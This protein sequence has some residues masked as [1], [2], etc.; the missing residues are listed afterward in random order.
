MFYTG[1]PRLIVVV[2]HNI[3]IADQPLLA[4]FMLL[5]LLFFFDRMY[6]KV[7]PGVCTNVTLRIL[8]YNLVYD[9]SKLDS[10][11]EVITA[12]LKHIVARHK[13]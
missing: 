13:K 1:A 5:L 6:C 10:Q 4:D 11:N 7:D 8:R 3:R 9:G 12:K 2:M